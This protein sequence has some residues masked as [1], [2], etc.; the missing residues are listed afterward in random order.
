MH[1]RTASKQ[2]LRYQPRLYSIDV[3]CIYLSVNYIFTASKIRLKKRNLTMYRP[4]INLLVSFIFSGSLFLISCKK[5]DQ[6]ASV[7]TLITGTKWHLDALYI[8]DSPYVQRT[9]FTTQY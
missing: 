5:S 4:G 3:L 6:P 1:P 8:I 7:V 2:F 9:N